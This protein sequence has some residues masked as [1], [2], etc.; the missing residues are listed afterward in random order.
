MTPLPQS[1]LKVLKDNWVDGQFDTEGVAQ[2]RLFDAIRA[3]AAAPDWK[4]RAK[5]LGLEDKEIEEL[6]VLF[7]DDRFAEFF[8][9]IRDEF[10][11]A[12]SQI[13]YYSDRDR[14][15]IETDNFSR[16]F[17]VFDDGCTSIQ[18]I[19]TLGDAMDVIG[20]TLMGEP[21]RSKR[22]QY[23][24]DDVLPVLLIMTCVGWIHRDIKHP[25]LPSR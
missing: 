14:K 22:F 3:F 15:T 11:G 9:C 6:S 12:P 16:C 13:L 23:H 4:E 7:E 24:T 25:R 21:Y 1:D 17:T 20:Q 10:R 5:A 2:R 8:L 19:P 18:H